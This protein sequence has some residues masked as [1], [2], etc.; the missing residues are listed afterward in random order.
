LHHDGPFR[1]R[2]F[3]GDNYYAPLYPGRIQQQK[4]LTAERYLSNPLSSADQHLLSSFVQ[5]QF[6]G[7]PLEGNYTLRIYDA[8]EL[9]WSRL[10]DVQIFMRY[11]YWTRLE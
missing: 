11:R 6:R 9:D 3:E 7:R 8:P 4:A 2:N 10:E 5:G 1:V